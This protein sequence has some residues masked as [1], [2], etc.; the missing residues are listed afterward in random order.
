MT[1]PVATRGWQFDAAPTP[2]DPAASSRRW[3]F[4]IMA[5]VCASWVIALGL[6]F[7]TA[8]AILS[9]VGYIG[10]VLGVKRPAAGLVGIAILSSLDAPARVYLLTGGV[11]RWNTTNYWL[12]VYSLLFL[13]TMFKWRDPHTKLAALMLALLGIGLV[14]TPEMEFGVQHTFGFAAFFGITLYFYRAR[15][16]EDLLYW[17]G[18]ICGTLTALGSLVFLLQKAILHSINPNAYATFPLSGILAICL[19]FRYAVAKS[20]GRVL[21]CVLAAANMGA[22]FLTGSRGNML[23]AIAAGIYLTVSLPGVHTRALALALGALVTLA[24]ATQFTSMQDVAVHRIDK[25]LDPTE[26]MTA[27]TSGRWDLAL[28]GIEMFKEHP[29]GVGTGGFAKGWQDLGVVEG[30]SSFRRGEEFQAHSAWAK[31]MAE[32][33]VPGIVTLVAFVFSFAWVGL[34]RSDRGLMWLGVLTTLTLATAFLSTEFQAKSLWFIAGGTTILLHYPPRRR[35][36]VEPIG[37][38]ADPGAPIDPRGYLTLPLRS[39]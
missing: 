37:D 8:L 1:A 22:I 2:I 16:E 35:A 7:R 3:V 25:M 34:R 10:C 39:R 38:V 9:I 14:I 21:M 13:P 18:I 17:I 12:L 36:P 31:T 33:G 32:N 24:V 28:G 26:S 20:R 27:R 30:I 4:A 6:G 19:G 11:W 5:I 23:I 15:D 29:L